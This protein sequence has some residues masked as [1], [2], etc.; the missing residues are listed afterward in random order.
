MQSTRPRLR[1]VLART[2]A[3]VV[4][5]LALV[6]AGPAAAQAAPCAMPTTQPA[7]ADFADGSVAFRQQIFGRPGVIAATAGGGIATQMIAA[8]AT[9]AY[10][11]MNLP[12]YVGTPAA[13][14]PADEVIDN[15]DFLQA[16]AVRAT[17]C[18]TP[19][20]AL[21]ELLLPNATAPFTGTNLRYRS[22]VLTFVRHLATYG[23]RVFLLIP[24]S[25]PNTRD[26]AARAYWRRIA[27]AADI[28][29]EAYYS[30][31]AMNAVGPLLAS[32]DSRIDMRRRLDQL[33]A[34]GVPPERLGL[35]LGF[36]GRQ[37]GRMG[38]QPASA[39]F[40]FVK[41]QAL[42]AR[43][44]AAEIPI[45][46]I[47]SWGWRTSGLE[48]LD[49]DKAQAACVYLWTRSPTLCDAPATAAFDTSLTEGQIIVPAG[50]SCTT[51][52]GATITDARTARWTTILHSTAAA[53]TLLLDRIAAAA[54][55]V[56][57]SSLTRVE[58]GVV[59]RE[60]K[61]SR[62]AYRA[63]LAKA[64]V[65]RTEARLI[66]LD[67]IH[68]ASYAAASRTPRPSALAVRTWYRSHRSTLVR[69][70]R[71]A[72]AQPVLGGRRAGFALYGFVA[73][74]AVFTRTGGISTLATAT[75]KVPLRVS[76]PAVR[77]RAVRLAKATPTIRALLQR[78]ADA[79]AGA[80]ARVGAQQAT[81][82]AMTCLGDVLPAAGVP[83]APLAR[84]ALD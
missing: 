10:W 55:P 40:E 11:E 75:G 29:V 50:S 4:A 64:G 52:S 12:S 33:R 2:L 7:W 6:A 71:S 47:W 66:L 43:Q 53:G 56:T 69:P 80:V 83:G 1:G 21:N 58:S 82:D 3:P 34:I 23:D 48:S 31:P 70:V 16:R 72:S 46:T 45:A 35:I 77:L 24:P 59:A 5:V 61:G 44:V 22:N 25:G 79:S 39:W 76:G 9:G 41:L 84:F 15:A 32:R 54:I 38:L 78:S 81:L 17:G 49:P 19:W 63:F 37:G 51:T 74:S 18:E 65:S 67:E 62:A 57:A 36:Q 30:A 73:S 8:G 14:V 27:K 68:A 13:P 60:F 20:I 26:S 28:V 42:A